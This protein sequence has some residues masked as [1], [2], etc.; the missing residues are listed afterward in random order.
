MKARICHQLSAIFALPIAT[1]ATSQAQDQ[2]PPVALTKLKV[3]ALHGEI[4]ADPYFGLRDDRRSAP[5]ALLLKTNMGAGHGGRSGRYDY[6]KEM[7]FRYAFLLD[8]VEIA[9]P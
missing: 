5:D 4:R 7:A 2:T 6:L 8:Q 3:D 9:V 1:G